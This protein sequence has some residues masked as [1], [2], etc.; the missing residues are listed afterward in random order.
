MKVRDR[1]TKD[2]VTVGPDASVS[3]TAGLMKHKKIRRVP[4]MDRGRIIGIVTESDLNR[5]APSSAT[6]LS[7]NELNYLL[8]KL[9]IKDLLPKD[10]PLVTVEADCYIEMAARLMREHRISGL[11]V[12]EAGALAGIITETDIFS[13]LID[14]LDVKKNHTRLDI[15]AEERLGALAEITGIMAEHKFNIINFVAFFDDARGQYKMIFRLEG[16]SLELPPEL[17]EKFNVESV[18]SV[19]EF[20]DGAE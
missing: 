7:K 1:M 16:S 17:A 13:A 5:A 10:Q 15:Y 6:A 8:A 12:T 19:R 3:E 9:T 14:I 2:V 4:V 20:S 18:V 11:P